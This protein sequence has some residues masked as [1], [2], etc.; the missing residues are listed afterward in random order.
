MNEKRSGYGKF[1]RLH[2]DKSMVFLYY[3]IGVETDIEKVNIIST[4]KSDERRAGYLLVYDVISDV[5]T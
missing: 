3:V 5:I 1:Y 2:G 4:H